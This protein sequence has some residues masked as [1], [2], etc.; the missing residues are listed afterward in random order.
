MCAC[1]GEGRIF[2]R[3][4]NRKEDTDMK[5]KIIELILAY[6]EYKEALKEFHEEPE[7]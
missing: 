4:Y 1:V 5:D 2:Y 6:K 3:L 7:D